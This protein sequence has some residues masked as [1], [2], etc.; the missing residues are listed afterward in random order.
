MMV[1]REFKHLSKSLSEKGLF[2]LIWRRL[3][4]PVF[5][6]FSFS[7][8]PT[9]LNL[10]SA[11]VL[12]VVDIH[13]ELSSS[14][15]VSGTIAL[16]TIQVPSVYRKGMISGEFEKT[17][18]PFFPVS[19]TVNGL[20]ETFEAVLAVPYERKPGP[21]I[22]T[23]H[24]GKGE[25]A[26][27]YPISFNVVEGDYRSEVLH[28]DGRR[29]NPHHKKD[30]LRIKGEQERVAQIYGRVTPQKY[31]SGPFSYPI[32]SPVTSPFGTKRLYNGQLKN[33]HTGLDLKAPMKTPIY[34]A[35]AGM[36]VLASNL[37]YTGNTVM[38]DH[39]YGVITL[40]AHMSRIKVKEGQVIQAHQLVGLSGKTGRVNGPHLHWQAVVHRVKVNPIGLTEVMK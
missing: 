1:I 35:E 11:A 37:F 36:V 23:V 17:E 12:P 13:A 39:G 16:I 25:T 4:V 33:F 15:V 27:S 38:I 7:C 22:V 6:L 32:Q 3:F 30:L 28:V 26:K 2:G 9:H 31:W 34:S 8:A 14:Q 5:L 21:G 18:F 29:V 10:Q 24:I 20:I 19:E 40:Y